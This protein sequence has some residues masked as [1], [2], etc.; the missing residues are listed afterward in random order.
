[1]VLVA[2]YSG[3][4]K[5]AVINEVHKPIAEKRGYFIKGKFDQFQRNIPFS[6]FVQAFRD[7]MGQLLG[8]SDAQ[9]QRWKDKILD[10]LGDN[11]RVILE[12]IPELQQIIGEQPPVPELEG[13]AAQNRFNLLLQKFVGV[14]ATR[15]H[16][17]TL[18]IDDLQWADSASLNLLK[19]LMEESESSYLLILGAYRDNEVFPAHPLMLTQRE[20]QKREANLQVL[21]LAPLNEKNID[22]LVA[23][24]LLCSQE[25]AAPLSQLVY[26]KTK[27]NPFFA[28]QFLQGL[29]EDGCI[30]FIPPRTSPLTK[31]GLRGDGG[32]QCDLTRVQQLALTDDVVE[33]MVGRLQ[34]LSEGTREVLKL[35]ACIGNRF[36]LATLAVTCEES[37]EQVA[38]NLWGALQE[39]FIIPE[40]QTYKFFQGDRDAGKGIEALSVSYRFLHDRVQQAAYALIP[41]AQKQ[42]THY[43][44]GQLLLHQIPP[45]RREERIFEIVGQLNYGTTLIREQ[46]ERDELAQLN[47]IASRRARSATA[48]QA[49]REYIET[50]LSLLGGEAWQRQYEMTLAFHDLG[51]E[52]ASLSGDF[53]AMEKLVET[54][55]QQARTLLEG[56]NVYRVRIFANASRNQL[57]EAIAI[58]L[59][60]LQQLGV[61][62][63]ETPTENDIKQAIGELYQAIAGRDI[64]DLIDL[65]RMRDGEKIAIVQ[66]ANSIIPA[67]YIAKPPLFPVLTILAARFSIQYGN[68]PAS[69]FAYANYGVIACNLLHDVDGGVKFGRL[70]LQ[71]ASHPEAKAIEPEIF[72]VVGAFIV[73]RQSH[74]Q[75]TLGLTQKGYAKALE[76]G[77]LVS[78]GFNAHTFCGSALCSGR[79]LATLEQEVR[80]YSHALVQL[81][82]G[83]TGNYCRIYWQTC[84]NLLGVAESG[85]ILSGEALQEAEFLPQLL[86]TRDFL[87]LYIFYVYKLMLACIFA[88]FANSRDYVVACRRYLKAAIG[89]AIEPQLY[90]YDSLSALAA[91]SPTATPEKIAEICQQVEQNQNQLQQ[92]WAHYAPMNYQHKV[93]L[94]EAEKYRVVGKNYEAGDGYDRAIATATQNGYVHEEALANEL[95][96]KFYL[97]WGKPKIACT[98]MQEAYYAYARWGA[99]AK[100]DDLEGR[101]PQCL[102]PILER[103]QLPLTSGTMTASLNGGTGCATTPSSTTTKT[104]NPFDFASL[105]K[106]SRTLSEAIDLDRAIANLMQVVRENAGAETVA[107]MLFEGQTLMLEALVAPDRIDPIATIPVEESDLL[108]H[109]IINTV[110]HGRQP[111]AIDNASDIPAYAGDAYIQHHRPQSILCVPLVVRGGALQEHRPRAIGLLY[112]ENNQ[113]AG[114]FSGDRVEVLNLLCSQAAI[115]LE[116]ARLYRQAQQ[117]MHDLQ[118]AQLQMVQNE[119]MATLGNLVAGVAHEINNPVG[120]IGGNISAAGEHLQDLLAALSLYREAYPEPEPE[121]A[122]ELEDLD[123]EFIAEDF[124]K[125]VASMQSG[126]D[127]IAKISTSLRTFSRTDTD[128]KTEFNVHDGLDSTLLIL[129]YRLKANEQRPAIEVIKEYGEIPEV[130]CYAGQINQVFMNLLANAIDALDESNEGKSFAEIET[131]P[132]RITIATEFSPDRQ[133]IIIRIA[134]N[135]TGMSEEVKARLFEQGFTT[136]GVGKGTGLGMAISQQIIEEKHGGAIACHSKLGKGTKF[137]ITLPIS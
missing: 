38:T 17:L 116:N 67:A 54:A 125:L 92:H 63:P 29:H 58:A 98:Y 25:I 132:N 35:A 104:S 89:S 123:V 88:E 134:D 87:G 10:A 5:T 32:W 121:L 59:D 97:N 118:R 33:F 113:C 39:G 57:T 56:V 16:P 112:L 8:E 86:S 71:L 52:L 53:A 62:I 108:P 23:D 51:A 131:S 24:T 84:L 90:F 136:K 13:S 28:T 6:A 64:E 72:M 94:V 107:L 60:L 65:P 109:A 49:G 76:V 21:T 69:A 7:L 99:K 81:N 96:A 41:E 15:E 83:T 27:G 73:H 137:M 127:R 85:S 55:I 50:G 45:E 1:M 91:L 74:L 80:A 12:T 82:Q 135:G 26:Q 37:Q 122:E 48:Y 4:G 34:K 126:V 101:Y 11:G 70:A 133:S 30:T 106:A 22:R 129:K 68:I 61:T 2:G 40:N 117:A 102:A 111:L 114:V 124:P 105:M 14:F 77:N 120:F 43:H 79:S 78:V 128:A 93:E 18:F 42:N 100:T 130:K 75:E 31:G 46:Q 47:L 115:S 110:K 36:D 20:L 66:V 19:L 95:A 44:I 3:I 119:K 9:L 103:Q